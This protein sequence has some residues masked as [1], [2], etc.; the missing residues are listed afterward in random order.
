MRLE[1]AEGPEADELTATMGTA[2]AGAGEWVCVEPAVTR[3][4]ASHMRAATTR[5][6][7]SATAPI[8]ATFRRREL[9]ARA[10]SV[11]L[12]VSQSDT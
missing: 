6:A 4:A 8:A 10:R 2:A 9:R 12:S 3:V 5:T 1:E 7:A 11:R